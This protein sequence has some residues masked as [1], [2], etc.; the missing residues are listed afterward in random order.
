LISALHK[1]HLGEPKLAFY[2]R[3]WIKRLID[4]SFSQIIQ[5]RQYFELK[6]S[7]WLS[8]PILKKI[9]EK[10]LRT[11]IKYAYYNVEYY[12][13][14][15]KSLNL[16]PSDIKNVNDLSQI[17]ILTKSQIQ[18]K[19][20]KI[21][22]CNIDKN[23][24]TSSSTSGSTGKPLT[25][26]FDKNAMANMKSRHLRNYFES[27]GHLRDKIAHFT[28]PNR[29]G[30]TTWFHH[31]GFL[32][33]KYLS[34]FEKIDNHISNLLEI[35]P[36]VIEGYPSILWLIANT[37]QDKNIEG[38]NPRLIFSTAELLSQNVRKKINSA[39]GIEL[40]D[41]YGSAE[42]GTFAWECQEHNGYHMDIESVVVEFIKNG[43]NAS[44]GEKGDI[45]VTGLFNFAMPLIRYSLGDVGSYNIGQCS[46]GRRLPLMKI[47]EGR[48]D[49]FLVLPSGTIISP[50]N[51]NFLEN[52][53]G[54]A[55][56]RIIQKKPNKILV[57]V[58][59]GTDFSQKT[60][61]RAKDE[62][63]SGC[64]GEDIIISVEIVDQIPRDKSGKISAVV[65]EVKKPLSNQH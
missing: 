48:T 55:E 49:D 33:K 50:R 22:A 16:T 25:L 17:P 27:G 14:L 12:H 24:C 37:V 46:C 31:L 9:Q 4:N 29:F 47:I 60:I 53:D 51:I 65:S 3:K 2:Q 35:S 52:V 61:S 63:R 8:R 34:V 20:Q 38:L 36:D 7:Q 54:I 11:I 23:S 21:I 6:K 40:F 15:F 5:S 28:N 18:N 43:E 39:F 59:K 10:K 30:H 44:P 19:S 64:L 42:F 57:Q 62:I 26:L 1:N 56:Y 58:T 45:V 41:Q 13:A 32:S